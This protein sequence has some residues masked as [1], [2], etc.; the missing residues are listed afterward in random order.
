MDK[1]TQAHTL[2]H[3][4]VVKE[5]F[6]LFFFFAFTLFF[7]LRAL[8]IKNNNNGYLVTSSESNNRGDCKRPCMAQGKVSPLSIQKREVRGVRVAL[9]YNGLN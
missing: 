7:L 9:S 8:L 5:G 4:R 1:Q 6:L 2:I 3:L